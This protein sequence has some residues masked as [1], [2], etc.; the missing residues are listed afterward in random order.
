MLLRNSEVGYEG[1]KKA[2]AEGKFLLGNITG[3][4][5]SKNNS[6]I[7]IDR[8]RLPRR[9]KELEK[10]ETVFPR[11]IQNVAN[12]RP[13]AIEKKMIKFNQ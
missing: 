13:T 10:N 7:P 5:N 1:L 11:C 9:N 6:K 2:G 12:K 3:L 8:I 4:N